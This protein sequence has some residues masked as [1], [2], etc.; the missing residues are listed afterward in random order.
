MA[1][2]IFDIVLLLVIVAFVVFSAKKG[3][4]LSLLNTIAVALSGIF[5][6]KFSG[7]LSEFIFS[8]FL[9][10]KIELRFNDI[11]SNLSSGATHSG[12]LD[13][14][15]ESLPQGFVKAA[16]GFGFNLEYALETAMMAD[17]SSNEEF[18]KSFIDSIASGIIKPV[19]EVIVFILLFIV[20]SIVFKY[21][22]SLLDKVIKITPI[23]GKANTAL[24]GVLGAVK[25]LVFVFVICFVVCPIIFAIDNPSLK[26]T[27]TSSVIYGFIIEN[28]PFIGLV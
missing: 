13:A 26:D 23:V 25:A 18:V 8:S 9:Y 22:A 21:V 5:S 6:Y 16:E 15:V 10:D 14:L 7:I 12:K 27:I 4:A 19:L 11:L 17:Y 28:N 20:L 24:G 1:V 3:F 2:S